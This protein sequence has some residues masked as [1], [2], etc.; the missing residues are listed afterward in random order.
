MSAVVGREANNNTILGNR[1]DGILNPNGT[2]ADTAVPSGVRTGIGN[3]NSL[4]LATG[5]PAHGIA[6][7]AQMDVMA[8][9]KSFESALP[10]I[11][12]QTTAAVGA[13]LRPIAPASPPSSNGS[14][15]GSAAP[16]ESA[17]LYSRPVT[18]GSLRAN[19]TLLPSVN[20]T[21]SNSAQIIAAGDDANGN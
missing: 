6:T 4:A 3:M 7:Q 1:G 14:D 16:A 17:P 21:T 15:V 10:T 18:P 8:Q 12:T 13:L 5:D 11:P 20:N 9:V 2:N 19:R